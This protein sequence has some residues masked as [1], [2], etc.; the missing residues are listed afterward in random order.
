MSHHGKSGSFALWY[1]L[2][3]LMS[4]VLAKWVAFRVYIPNILTTARLFSPVYLWPLFS[5]GYGMTFL[6]LAVCAAATDWLDGK[7]ARR[8][9]CETPG[10]AAMDIFADKF[11]CLTLMAAGMIAW[12][13]LTIYVVLIGPLVLYHVVVIFRRAMGR[14]EFKSSY[15]AKVKMVIEMTGLISSLWSTCNGLDVAWIDTFMDR[16]S[17]AELLLATVILAPWSMAHYFGLVRDIYMPTKA[18]A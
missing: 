11:L 6:A 1:I 15:V 13:T 18:A 3:V 2:F 7:L 16:F 17:I 9:S 8:W 5:G 14:A 4:Y 12:N 10:G